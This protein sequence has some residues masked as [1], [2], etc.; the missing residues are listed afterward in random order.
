M[1]NVTAPARLMSNG[2]IVTE[3]IDTA[4]TA[5]T[6]Y[7]FPTQKD[8]LSITNLGVSEIALS[9]GSY[10]NETIQ[11]S[12]SK[13]YTLFFTSFTVSCSQNTQP[14]EVTATL[15]KGDKLLNTNLVG[16]LTSYLGLVNEDFT[17]DNGTRI[18]IMPKDAVSTG[19]GGAIKIFGDAYHKDATNYRDTGL[20]F[21][22]D[23]NGDTGHNGTG[24]F[25]VNSKVNG[26]HAGKN[27]DLGFSFQDGTFVAGRFAYVVNGGQSYTCFIIGAGQAAFKGLDNNI[28]GEVQGNL[29]LR[30][31]D[32]IRWKN[33]AGTGMVDLFVDSTDIL[34]VSSSVGFG[35]FV[36][37]VEKLAVR[38]LTTT[39]NNAIIQNTYNATLNNATFDMTGYNR[40]KFAQTV[41]TTITN[42]TGTDGQRLTML[43]TNAFT[44]I[45]HGA[46]FKLKTGVNYVSAADETLVLENFGGVWYEITRSANHV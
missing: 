7:T 4:Q 28:R 34:K 26:I 10:T 33:N 21:S 24:V 32:R 37:G 36:G 22:A 43:F 20:Y 40:M 11:P 16:P 41:A 27:H 31:A 18:Y 3:F 23:Q 46:N 6:T 14:F 35:A 2:D 8:T 44:T 25:W 38:S 39:F 13:Q 42:I 12:E 19:L 17:G 15:S 5:S 45:Q 30:N 29:G 1:P 9:V